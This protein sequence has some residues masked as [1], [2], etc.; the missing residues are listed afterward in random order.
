MAEPVTGADA[1]SSAAQFNRYVFIVIIMAK[2][3]IYI[4]AFILISCIC[5]A[6]DWEDQPCVKETKALME[7]KTSWDEIFN[8][9]KELPFGCF[10][11]YFAEG[12][13]D[14]I[15]RKIGKEWKAFF[16]SYS[17]FKN[18]PRV[19]IIIFGSLNASLNTEDLKNIVRLSQN[20]CPEGQDK[21]CNILGSKAET[22]L[23]EIYKYEKHNQR[24]KSD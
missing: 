23:D 6:G 10:D 21:I 20:N 7:I 19:N 9:L 15:A 8:S 1:K 4:A 3:F 13:S 17:S 12:I 11:G 24:I 14:T 5:F 22:A 18:D 16:T 2:I